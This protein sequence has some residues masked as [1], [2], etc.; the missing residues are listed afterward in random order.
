MRIDS[1]R[2]VP[3]SRAAIGAIASLVL[4]YVAEVFS[5]DLGVDALVLTGYILAGIVFAVSGRHSGEDTDGPPGAAR[6][7][8]ALRS[9]SALLFAGGAVAAVG[10]NL[11]A[12]QS[13]YDTLRTGNSSAVGP[14]LWILSLLVLLVAAVGAR[15]LPTWPAAWCPSP[16]PSSPRARRVLI[17]TLVLIVVGA[18][19][20]RLIKLDRVPWGINADEGDRTA[21]AMSLLSG[22]GTQY[23]FGEG[24]YF[25]PNV[26]FWLLGGVLKVLGV[27]FVQARVLGAICSIL[28]L[29]VIVWIALR[30]FGA[31]VALLTAILGATLAVSL[32]FARETT[33]AT[34]TALLWALSVAFLLEAA[35]S[36]STW[37]WAAA[38]I[39]GGLSLYFYPS[40]RLW[41]ALA[42]LA[43]LHIVLRAG[44]DRRRAALAGVSLTATAALLTLGPFLARVH[45]FPEQLYLRANETSVFSDDNATRLWYYNPGWNRAELLWAQV[46]H[47]LGIFANV[48]DGGGFWPTG[49]PILGTA[50]TVLVFVGLGWFTLSWRHTPRFTLALWFWIGIAG[51]VVT[52]ET[53][54][55][56]RMA[57]AVPV[58]PLLA[59]SVIDATAVRLIRWSRVAGASVA[60]AAPIVVGTAAVGFAAALAAQQA[61]FYFV[62]YAHMYR[63]PQ[64]TMQG[65]A[66]ADQGRDALVMSFGRQ[67]MQ[68]NSGW[69]RM[70]A[71]H[72]DRGSVLS[73]GT[74]LP[75]PVPATRDLAFVV[76][77]D[78]LAYLPFLRNVYPGGSLRRYTYVSEGTIVSVYRIPRAR[79]AARAG[80]VAT[81]ASGS[82]AHVNALGAVPPG[83][84]P[85]AVIRWSAELHVP[86]YWNY[87]LRLKRGPA[88]LRIDGKEELRLQTGRTEAQVTVALA[89]GRHFVTVDGVAAASGGPVLEWRAPPAGNAQRL[90]GFA[91]WRP[92]AT[93]E[94]MAAVAPHGLLATVR[95]VGVP[96]EQRLDGTVATCC[97]TGDV[98]AGGNPYVVRWVGT[99]HAPKSGS[100]AMWLFTQGIAVL[101]VDGRLVLRSRSAADAVSFGRLRLREGEHKVVLSYRVVGTAGGIEWSW[102][103]PGLPASIVPPSALEP[104]SGA[105][106]GPRVPLDTLSGQ[107]ID[108]PLDVKN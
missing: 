18:C 87:S 79:V 33:E 14:V 37:P 66:V 69:V 90:P 92:I 38:G 8:A 72:V 41:V 25:I 105:G 34:P 35:R 61:H 78:Q 82:P 107:P 88:V 101:Q 22:H 27:G 43:C 104:P 32:Q 99:L 98:L 28:T 50:L 65:Q 46:Q 51:M 45:A 85:S 55:L 16:L 57:T 91:T 20:A 12:D 97:L 17:A 93:S 3:R 39:S 26:Y 86:A 108:V 29:C 42:G 71:P 59:A 67:S 1:A 49:K 4:A 19:V 52:V 58:L 11:A 100:Y 24:W 53:P 7:G 5:R 9:R 70:L 89:R 13:V 103:P 15:P 36:G 56:Q 44:A 75:L 95:G 76:Y 21:T 47:S 96:P 23:L 63:W 80:S 68:I 84:S 48:G 102:A 94:L 62:T 6:V 31:R 10:L 106:V 64:P 2:S 73:P 30:H 81:P 40:G 60:R 74:L 54:N 83:V 77:P